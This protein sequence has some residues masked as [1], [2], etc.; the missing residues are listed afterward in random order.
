MQVITDTIIYIVISKERCFIKETAICNILS[1]I[2]NNFLIN[3]FGR[4]CQTVQ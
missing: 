2:Y 3:L 1:L 4:I